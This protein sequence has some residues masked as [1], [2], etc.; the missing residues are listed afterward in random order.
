MTSTPPVSGKLRVRRTL[1][2]LAV[3]WSIGGLFLALEAVMR[4]LASSISASKSLP[5]NLVR[6]KQSH[7]AFLHCQ[8]VVRGLPAPAETPDIAR[9]APYLAW[10]IG[11][12]LGSADASIAAGVAKQAA[13]EKAKSDGDTRMEKEYPS[14]FT[15]IRA[16][17]AE[18]K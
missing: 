7:A 2:F 14:L 15:M 16:E 13:V 9:Q 5:A 3:V 11:F 6:P 1:V 8:E 4:E 12:M 10:R 17:A 18:G